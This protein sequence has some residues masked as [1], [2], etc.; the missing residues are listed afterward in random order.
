MESLVPFILYAVFSKS[1]CRQYSRDL[2]CGTELQQLAIFN[3]PLIIYLK[4][5][6]LQDELG[7]SISIFLKPIGTIG[8]YF[9]IVSVI[10]IMKIKPFSLKIGL[11]F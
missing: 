4:Y 5:L 10:D 11:F 2:R 3:F 7:S 8:N 1:D 6:I 9:L